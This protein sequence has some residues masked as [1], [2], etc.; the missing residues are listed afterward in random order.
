MS[1][2]F[3]STGAWP[4]ALACESLLDWRWRSSATMASRVFGKWS[5]SVSSG[6][7]ARG[8]RVRMERQTASDPLASPSQTQAAS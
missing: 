1:G 7:W 6:S 4:R 8:G 2:A 5:R 3:A